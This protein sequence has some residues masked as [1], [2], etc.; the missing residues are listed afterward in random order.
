MMD[1]FYFYLPNKIIRNSFLRVTK[2]PSLEIDKI[3]SYTLIMISF[4]LINV[5]DDEKKTTPMQINAWI[6]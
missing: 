3:H 4:S 2:R 6:V 5:F 1:Q